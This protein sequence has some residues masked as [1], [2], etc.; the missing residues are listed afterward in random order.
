MVG[1][2]CTVDEDLSDFLAIVH[3]WFVAR[4]ILQRNLLRYDPRLRWMRKDADRVGVLH[5]PL[6]VVLSRLCE[7]VQH[8]CFKKGDPN[9]PRLPVFGS[10][11][12]P[13]STVQIDVMDLIERG[14]RMMPTAPKVLMSSGQTTEQQS[15]LLSMA[16]ISIA[17]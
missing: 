4:D 7:R 13:P 3:P 14:L 17:F 10:R 1:D 12:V 15:S 8:P 16:H 11:L 6:V 9:P 2:F 5:I